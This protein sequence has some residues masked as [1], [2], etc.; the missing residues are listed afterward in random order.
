MTLEIFEGLRAFHV[1][2]DWFAAYWLRPVERG[3]GQGT[4]SFFARSQAWLSSWPGRIRWARQVVRELPQECAPLVN[5]N[6]VVQARQLLLGIDSYLGDPPT[7]ATATN[8]GA[9]AARRHAY[10]L[11]LWGWCAIKENRERAR[12]RESL[13]RLTDWE[14]QD[15]GIY[16]GE[17]EHI[18]SADG[19]AVRGY[20]T[21][22]TSIGRPEQCDPL[23]QHRP[24]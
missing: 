22:S 15:I 20:T 13:H 24:F 10:D 4:A 23:V 9:R 18:V 8:Q 1:G 6:D 11:I 7:T 2:R 19:Q 3:I 5:G 21:G 14:L 12:L 17:I 16:R